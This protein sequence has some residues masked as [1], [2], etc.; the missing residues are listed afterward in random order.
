MV[1]NVSLL[2]LAAAVLPLFAISPPSQPVSGPGGSNYDYASVSIY[3]PFNDGPS[4]PGPGC[5]GGLDYYIYQPASPQ[6]SSPL[7]LVLFLHGYSVDDPSLY[8]GWIEHIVKKGYTVVWVNYDNGGTLGGSTVIYNEITAFKDAISRI[9]GDSSYVQPAVN[10]KG[11]IR[12]A[13][14]GHSA[15]ALTGFRVA[16]LSSDPA[17][18]IPPIH[19]VAA[20]NPGQGALPDYD[21]SEIAPSTM[22]VI[23]VGSDETSCEQY[24]GAKL[25][26]QLPMLPTSQKVFLEAW[27]DSHGSPA[28]SAVHPFPATFPPTYPIDALDWSVSYKMSVALFDCTFYGKTCLAAV[29][30][31]PQQTS[32]GLWSDNVPVKPMTH[33]TTD[34]QIAF[35]WPAD[36]SCTQ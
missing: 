17:N 24:V 11:V 21:I 28:L 22:A 26:D 34:P 33:F 6:P 15:G 1:Y 29:A 19:A 18:G 32:M 10:A 7:P 8:E 35:P 27:S 5:N 9:T 20:I 25:Y 14:A 13:I 3:G 30:N 4:C 2:T 12:A 31:V 23:V 16:A 36:S